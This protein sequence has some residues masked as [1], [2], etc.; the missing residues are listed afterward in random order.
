MN[1]SPLPFYYSALLVALGGATG[2][3]SRWLIS[4][5]LNAIYPPLPPGTLVANYLGAFLMG[6]GLA[7]F[8]LLQQVHEGWRLLLFTG[9]LGGLSTF[10]TFSAEIMHLIQAQRYAWAFF[11]VAAHVCGSLLMVALGILCVQFFKP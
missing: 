6:L 7:A 1:A 9:F 4:L 5:G 3:V 10:S 11:G 8:G 2:A